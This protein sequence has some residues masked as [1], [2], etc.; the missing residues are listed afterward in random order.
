M[1]YLQWSNLIGIRKCCNYHKNGRRI[2]SNDSIRIGINTCCISQH[3]QKKYLTEE[4]DVIFIAVL[5]L[6]LIKEPL[7]LLILRTLGW[8][9]GFGF[10]FRFSC[11]GV[12][13][14]IHCYHIGYLVVFHVSI[15]TTE[16]QSW[17]HG[18]NT[19]NVSWGVEFSKWKYCM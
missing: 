16:M 6:I 17:S 1:Y 8:I 9:L 15:N 14:W 3:F 18:R 4:I 19:Y 13:H 12:F 10:G 7:Q 2:L 11:I 5:V